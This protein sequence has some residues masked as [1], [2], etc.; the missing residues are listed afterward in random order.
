MGGGST[1]DVSGAVTAIQGIPIETVGVALLGIAAVAMGF[2]WL[3]A[4]FF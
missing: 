3:K 2:K 1:F 4:M